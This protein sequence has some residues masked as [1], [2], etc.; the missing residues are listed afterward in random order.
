MNRFYVA[1][2]SANPRRP[3][4]LLPLLLLACSTE[5]P[6]TPAEPPAPRVLAPS[7]GHPPPLPPTEHWVHEDAEM[8]NK[9]R[10]KQYVR[11]RHRAP[12]DVDVKAVERANGLAAL[13][14]RNL[15][16]RQRTADPFGARWVERGSEN[17]AGRMM[18]A[19]RSA[20]GSQLYAGSSLG[21]VWRGTPTGDDWEPLA[22]G[23]YGGAHWLLVF[24][25][26]TA[27]GPEVMLAA[28]DGGLM[29]R[30]ADDG[31]TWSEPSGLGDLWDVR[32]LVALEDGSETAFAVVRRAGGDWS[33]QRSTDHGATW[34]EIRDLGSYRGDVWVPR[35]GG[36]T[37]WLLDGTRLW[38][39]DDLGDTWI[40]QGTLPGAGSDGGELAG[41]EA[42]A[43]RFWVARH[44]DGGGRTLLRSDDAGQ[45]WTELRGLDDYW[46]VLVASIVDPELVAW[47]GVEVHRSGDGGDSFDVV[48]GWGDYYG[49]P[50]TKLHA[51][52]MGM[53]VFPDGDAETWFVGTDGGLYES[54]DGLLTVDNLSLRGLRVSQY[55]DVLT[56]VDD[57]TQ[58]AAGSQDQGYQLTNGIAQSEDSWDFD[59]VVSGDY[60]HLTSSDGT[61]D[62]VYSVYPGF[63]LV[64]IGGEEPELRYE[65]FPEDPLHAWLAPVVADP[66]RK[67]AVFFAGSRLWRYNYDADADRW[68]AEEWSDQS[69][70]QG[71]EYM[72]GLAFSPHDPQRAF[73]VTSLGRL[74]WS[75]DK[76]RTWTES[77]DLGP[78]GMWL[79]GTAILPSITDPDTVYV[80]G[81]GYGGPAIWRSKTGGRQWKPFDEGLPD[82]LV[83]SL[84]EAPDGSGVLFA[85]TESGAWRK[86]PGEDWT[87]IT[88]IDAPLTTYW[89]CEALQHENTVRWGT[90]G[91]GIWDYQL[92]PEGTGCFPPVDR[93]GDGVDCDLDCDDAD[94]DVFPGNKDTPC[95]AVDA[96]CDP[97]N[98]LS[99]TECE[100][101]AETGCGCATGGSVGW[102]WLLLPL[103]WRRRR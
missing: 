70:A 15:R 93:D 54:A 81:S 28:T 103:A 31:L 19:A 64:Q 40:E 16:V 80:G 34:S 57:P 6:P 51:D 101:R 21:G 3:V 67:R 14:R 2:H 39:S 72:S 58:V 97:T 85:G 76:G 9:A 89:S 42:G 53:D 52:I 35:D 47:G 62:Y 77:V 86:D 79:Y 27:G 88:G 10:R 45:S 18:V 29:H 69:F 65:D 20:D 92:D 55:Y 100:E 75:E 44:D 7:Q 66:E 30:S 8:T 49:D 102:V 98:E 82:T 43:P 26:D 48:N 46:G 83:Y 90:Y 33:V 38:S 56:S 68:L 94:P 1:R 32:R 99:V 41:S 25:P 24:P 37:V 11:E 84:C 61:H 91:R 95:D 60:G 59:Q 12:P 36:S 23:L 87:E 4:L 96:D 22:D 50:A 78:Q 13:A 63:L 71:Y 5:A 73:A 17:Q 74:F